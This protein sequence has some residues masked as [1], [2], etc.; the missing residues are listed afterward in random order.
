MTYRSSFPPIP[1]KTSPE[2]TSSMTLGV[3]LRSQLMDPQ[4]FTSDTGWGCMIRSGQSLLANTLC[5]LLLGRGEFMAA[6]TR[7]CT[8]LTRSTEWRRGDSPEEESRLLAMFADH[9]DAPLSIHR[10]VHHG[11]ESCGKYPGE[12][13]GPSATARCIQYVR[14]LL[15]HTKKKKTKQTDGKT[16]GD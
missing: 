11:A 3:R 6:L 8:K 15:S 10:F 5:I 12:W 7:P 16:T 9:P 4:G 2:A 1:R 13:F 14:S